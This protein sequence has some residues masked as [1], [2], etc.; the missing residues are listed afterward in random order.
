MFDDSDVSLNEGL[1]STL[2]DF[3]VSKIEEIIL[4]EC[5]A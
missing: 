5:S 4:L 2:F 1:S 3:I